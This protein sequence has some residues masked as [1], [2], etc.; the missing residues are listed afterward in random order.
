MDPPSRGKM[1]THLRFRFEGLEA[2]LEAENRDDKENL[3]SFARIPD[4]NPG[5]TI[6]VFN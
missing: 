1:V 5:R 3:N 4:P 6:L 2:K